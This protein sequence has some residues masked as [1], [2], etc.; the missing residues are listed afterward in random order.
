M[1]QYRFYI[2]DDGDHIL[3]HRDHACH[4]DVAALDLAKILYGDTGI[5]LCAGRRL[6]ARVNRRD[7]ISE[8][9]LSRPP[10]VS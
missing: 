9:H 6:I 4:D 3:T 2:L 7:R 10:N 1:N 5:E 8:R